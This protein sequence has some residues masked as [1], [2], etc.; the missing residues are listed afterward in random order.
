MFENIYTL[1]ERVLNNQKT[2]LTNSLKAIFH[3]TNVGYL[4]IVFQAKLCYNLTH[5]GIRP[6][7]HWHGQIQSQKWGEAYG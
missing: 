3:P 2:A 7:W 4:R 1:A 5:R 6:L